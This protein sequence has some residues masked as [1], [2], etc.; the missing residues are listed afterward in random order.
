MTGRDGGGPL[1]QQ[2]GT[3]CA[4]GKRGFT[5]RRAAKATA[6]SVRAGN[7]EHL[8]PYRCTD[9]ACGLWHVGHLPRAVIKGAISGAAYY[10]DRT[11]S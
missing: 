9:P 1:V 2:F 8:R 5:T 4:S 11:S 7:G 3:G 6:Q 10:D